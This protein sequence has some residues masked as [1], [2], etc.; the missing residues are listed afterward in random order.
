MIVGEHLVR[1]ERRGAFQC[2]VNIALFRHVLY[3]LIILAGGNGEDGKQHVRSCYVRCL[4]DAKAYVSVLVIAQVHFLAQC[5]RANLLRR[6]VFRQLETQR[7]EILCI[8]LRISE[9]L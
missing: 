2:F 8:D 4:I 9:F 5:D 6:N 7:I 3:L 1:E